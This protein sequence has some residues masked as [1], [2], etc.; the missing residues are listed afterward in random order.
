M[1]LAAPLTTAFLSVSASAQMLLDD[2][3][4]AGFQAFVI[5]LQEVVEAD[6]REALLAMVRFPLRVNDL[7]SSEPET[8]MFETRDELEARF[9][10]VFDSGFRL[11]V[12]AQN[13]KDVFSSYDGAMLGNGQI[14]FDYGCASEDCAEPGPVQ[15]FSINRVP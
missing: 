5:E 15:I 14:W 1:A 12:A 9:D 13:P 6:D 2:E 11:A 7:R 3:R 8:T 10:W 4:T